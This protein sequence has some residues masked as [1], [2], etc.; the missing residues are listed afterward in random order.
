MDS[1]AYVKATIVSILQPALTSYGI[2]AAQLPDDF[3]FRDNGVI[4]SLG[5]VQLLAE[6]ERRLERAVDVST[7]DPEQLTRFGS[8]ARHVAGRG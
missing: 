6:L 2:A 8:L 4:D 7:L 5:F 1:V 3:D